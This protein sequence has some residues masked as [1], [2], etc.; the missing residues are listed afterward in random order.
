MTMTSEKEKA[1]KTFDFRMS[2][3]VAELTQVVHMLFTRNHEKEVEIEALKDAYEYEISLVQED[4]IE[5]LK[6]S[7]EKRKELEKLL[8]NERKVSRERVKSAIQQ[9]A[10]TKE[11]QWKEK[12]KLLEQQLTDEK[13]ESQNLR[14]LL[15]NAQKDIEKLRQGVAEQLQSKNEEIH[16]K[17]QE[18]ERLRQKVANLEHTQ[19]ESEKHYKEIIRDLEKSNEK[20]ERELAQLQ[21]L[22][23]ETHRSKMHFE[24]KSQKL[25]TDLKNLRKDFSKKVSEVVASQRSQ[26]TH[27]LPAQRQYTPT[28]TMT[29]KDYNE[30]VEKLRR[31]VQ[32][33]RMELSNRDNNFNRMFTDGQQLMVDPRAGKIAITQQQVLAAG[34]TQSKSEPVLG[35][36]EKSFSYAFVQSLDE[37]KRPTSSRV[38][39][40]S[41]RL[42]ALTQEQKTRLT[43]L[44]KPRPLPKEMLYGK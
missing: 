31:E 1:K 27:Q 5:Q 7:E 13:N 25:E 29:I 32:R 12:V 16:R 10:S 38:S 14:D 36:R 40:A 34:P 22:L 35:N 28:G 20:L 30:E 9:E 21:A 11:E 33:Y 43:K 15:I 19:S 23:E 44:M 2:K 6:K 18:L 37:S 42:P 26:T 4:A 41:G 17:N 8:E 39:S 24:S 3:K